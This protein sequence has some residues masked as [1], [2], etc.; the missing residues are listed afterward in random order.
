MGFVCVLYSLCS[1]GK[2]DKFKYSYYIRTISSLRGC[3][4]A[5]ASTIQARIS[6][7]LI[8]QI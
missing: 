8:L 7:W 5:A 3:S 2:D 4:A 6:G 1:V